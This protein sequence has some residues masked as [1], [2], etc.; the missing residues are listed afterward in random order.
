MTTRTNVKHSQDY[1][2][3]TSFA[4]FLSIV[5]TLLFLLAGAFVGYL[6]YNSV[7]QTVASIEVP[8]LP[9]IDLSLPSVGG[10]SRPTIGVIPQRGGEIPI[11]GITGVPLPDYKQKQRVNIL[12]LGI[13]KRPDE[14]YARTDTMILVTIDPEN[15]TAGML[16]LPRDLWLEIPGYGESRINTAYYLGE[17]DGYP[18]GGPAL[19]MKTV[20]YNFGVPVHFYVEVDFDGFRKIVDTL[21][22]LDINV[23]YT[24]DDPTF[25]SDD[26]G[27][28][29]FHIDAGMQHMDGATALKYARTRHIDSDFG[30]AER[31]QQVLI[32]IKDKALQLGL[33]PKVPELWTTMAG[34]VKTD[35]QLVDILE[36]ANLAPDITP[37]KIETVVLDENY[38]VNYTTDGGAMVLL[39]LREKIQPVID[40]MFAEVKADEPSQAEII[41]AQAAQATQ[42][43][44]MQAQQQQREELKAQ[45]A[46]ENANIIIQNGTPTE[47][48]DA[49]TALFLKEQGFNIVQFGPAESTDYPRTVIV[50]YSDKDYTLGTLV[51]FFNVAPENVRRSPNLQSDVDI[52]VIIGADF[53][54]PEESPQSSLLK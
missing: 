36:L 50:T 24:L 23:P 1:Q 20:Q 16:S 30:R 10:S 17:K 22:G 33:L 45:L 39:P 43:A 34:T 32:A 35:L 26:Y 53:Q 44:Q 9:Y 41:A 21:G 2:L 19:A 18:G 28:D 46:A 37:D 5:F 48:L 31:Q 8:N 38:T 40:R 27:Y 52:R 14:Q 29:P 15:K 6:L 47:G 7:K 54:L 49:Q 42:T 4:R 11:T 12:L 25:P 51:N 3:P 13:D